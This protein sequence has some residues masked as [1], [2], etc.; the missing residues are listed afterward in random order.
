M[1][2]NTSPLFGLTP[3]IGR[4]RLATANST[5]DLGTTTNAAPAFTAGSNGSRVDQ[6]IFT[7]SG[8]EGTASSTAVVRAF[9]TDVS[10]TNA[11]LRREL[12]INTV[13]PSSTAIGATGTM[14]F[15]GGLIVPSGMYIYVS[16]SVS[17]GWD[18]VTE[19]V[20]F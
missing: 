3:N 16:T 6:I 15:P 1:P 17:T 19:G 12:L 8:A 13:T 4:A 9:L 5:R 18:V 20:D 7:H 10:G 2:A 14:T 11:K